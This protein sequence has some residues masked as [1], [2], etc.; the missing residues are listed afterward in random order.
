MGE[1]VTY[2]GGACH[3]R[4]VRV[5]LG[6]WLLRSL[7]ASVSKQAWKDADLPAEATSV[8]RGAVAFIQG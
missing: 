5:T 8:Q 6:V 4:G 3:L 2:G 7:R 1:H